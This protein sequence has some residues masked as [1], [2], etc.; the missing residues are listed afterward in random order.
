MVLAG[1]VSRAAALAPLA[2]LAPARADGAGASASAAGGAALGVRAMLPAAA[3]LTLIA[4][5]L[6]LLIAIGVQ[7]HTLRPLVLWELS[8]AESPSVA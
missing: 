8:A 3:A 6:G 2:W 7:G 4:V 5:G 1:A